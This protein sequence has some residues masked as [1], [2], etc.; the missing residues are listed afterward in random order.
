MAKD[1][2]EEV[3]RWTNAQLAHNDKV[4]SFAR[5]FTSHG[6]SHGSGNRV[7]QRTT[8]AGVDGIER[9]LDAVLF[10]ERVKSLLS[11]ETSPEQD[12]SILTEFD[13]AW[14]RRGEW[15]ALLNKWRPRQR[16]LIET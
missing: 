9:I 10:R 14:T 11:D 15:R 4:V 12:R 2:G 1:D 8:L 3:R 7:A 5:A 16:G 13:A 6:W